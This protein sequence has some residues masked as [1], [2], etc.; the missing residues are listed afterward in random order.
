[1]TDMGL[2]IR[3]LIRPDLFC[4]GSK[5]KTDCFGFTGEGCALTARKLERDFLETVKIKYKLYKR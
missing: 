1:M 2:C 5:C 4:E 3:I